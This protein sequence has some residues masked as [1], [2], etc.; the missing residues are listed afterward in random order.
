[1]TKLGNLIDGYLEKNVAQNISKACYSVF[2]FIAMSI[3]YI[4]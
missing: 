4:I 2:S 3:K 1:M